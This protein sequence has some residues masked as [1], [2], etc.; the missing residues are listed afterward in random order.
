MGA[1]TPTWY[2]VYSFAIVLRTEVLRNETCAARK[3]IG[4]TGIGMT[5]SRQAGRILTAII[6]YIVNA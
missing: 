2:Y 1:F 4:G 3:S 6:H 5:I